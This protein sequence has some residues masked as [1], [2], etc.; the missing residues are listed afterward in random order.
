MS[1]SPKFWNMH[2]DPNICFDGAATTLLTIQYNLAA[3][4]LGAFVTDRADIASI[5][6]DILNFKGIG[7]F[8][9]TE[10]EHGLDVFNLETTATLLDDG[11]FEFH[12]PHPG[13]AKFMPPTIPVLGRPCYAAVFARLIVAG[14]SQGIRTFVV[15]INDGFKMCPGISAKIL[16][17]RGNCAPVNHCLTSF[18]RVILPSSALLGEIDVSTPPRLHFLGSIWRV[19]VGTLALTSIVIPGFAIASH[20]AQRY[21][22]LRVVHSDG[23]LVPIFSFRTQQ[24]P[25]L[26]IIAQAFVLRAFHQHAIKLFADDEMSPFVR[27]GVATA[28]KAVLICDLQFSTIK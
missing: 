18:H 22:M 8:C 11:W 24:I 5:V 3:G 6:D 23:E 13:V 16:P 25:I 2:I 14:V 4:T 19:A 20:V 17:L 12:T 26:T 28:F 15:H 21:G 27:H 1:L 10:L 7:Q 9:L